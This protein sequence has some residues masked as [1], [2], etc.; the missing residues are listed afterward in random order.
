MA[1][2]KQPETL[3]DAGPPNETAQAAAALGRSIMTTLGRPTDFYRITVVRLWENHYR[4][5]V[6]TGLNPSAL[7]IAHSYFVSADDQGNVVN[8]TPPLARRY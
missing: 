6:L 4:V 2:V 7:A 3:P 8:S 1:K 5:N